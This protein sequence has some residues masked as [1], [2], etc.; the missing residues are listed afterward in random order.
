MGYSDK[1]LFRVALPNYDFGADANEKYSFRLPKRDNGDP[2]QGQL[3]KIGC[4]ITEAFAATTTP[5]SIE[6]GTA[7]DADAFAKLNIPD[8]AADVDCYDE[9]DDTDAIIADDIPAG[10]LLEVNLTQATDDT[11]DTGQGIPFFDFWVW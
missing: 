3:V 2:M 9:T 6:L 11:S 7:A 4:M 1:Q 5:A 10:T 8:L